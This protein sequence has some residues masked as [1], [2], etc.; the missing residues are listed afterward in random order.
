MS[1]LTKQV[2]P[3]PMFVWL[4]AGGAGIGLAYMLN[5]GT[6]GSSDSTG[7]LPVEGAGGI[8]PHGANPVIFAPGS[9]ST[10]GSDPTPPEA[11][12]TLEDWASQALALAV[13]QGWPT[14]D[15]SN[16]VTGML[17]QRELSPTQC[18]IA[19]RLLAM[20]PPPRPLPPIVCA[21]AEGG[22]P[23]PGSR[24]TQPVPEPSS[25]TGLPDAD[26]FHLLKQPGTSATKVR[27]VA[28][29]LARRGYRSSGDAR[30]DAH[31]LIGTRMREYLCSTGIDPTACGP[32]AGIANLR[33][34]ST[35]DLRHLLGQA[36]TAT[37]TK[38]AIRAELD[39]RGAS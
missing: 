23:D 20:M 25:V 38:A 32:G 3:F 27:A 8:L 9:G 15:A 17:Q 2:G 5:K 30:L 6:A 39:R 22:P 26:L 19:N 37:S 11:P 28:A 36:A 29:E 7:Y 31:P 35:P 12:M 34:M 16:A 10:E 18:V 1:F 24:P 14:L 13:S 21:D 4:A 33:A